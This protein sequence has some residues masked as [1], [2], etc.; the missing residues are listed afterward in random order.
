M[1]GVDVS[2]KLRERRNQGREVH[3]K[4]GRMSGQKWQTLKVLRGVYL[5]SQ[6]VEITQS[7]PM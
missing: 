7:M 3:L 1:K 5:A 6:G 2:A 4:I